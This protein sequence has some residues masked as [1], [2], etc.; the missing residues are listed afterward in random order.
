M[1]TTG[2]DAAASLHVMCADVAAVPLPLY[3]SVFVTPCACRL[4]AVLYMFCR[5]STGWQS[6]RWHMRI[7][8]KVS[9]LL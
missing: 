5:W 6:G 2:E 7:S 8:W 3:E 9:A 4:A 1:R